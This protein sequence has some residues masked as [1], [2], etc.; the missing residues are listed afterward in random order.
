MGNAV[1]AP[2]LQSSV[3]SARRRAQKLHCTMRRILPNALLVLGLYLAMLLLLAIASTVRLWQR[4]KMIC[5]TTTSTVSAC[6]ATV[7]LAWQQL[8]ATHFQNGGFPHLSPDRSA[9][10]VSSSSK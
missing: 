7:C 5:A 2:V 3:R 9:R 8:V 1:L 10:W 6:L 4:Q